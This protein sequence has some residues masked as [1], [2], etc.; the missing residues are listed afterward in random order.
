MAGECR[1]ARRIRIILDNASVHSS[2][3]A[4]QAI[5]QL[6]WSA[7][8]TTSLTQGGR[9][10]PLSAAVLPRGNLIERVWLNLHA[11]VTLTHRCRTIALFMDRVHGYLSGRNSQNSANPSLFRGDLRRTA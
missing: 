4:L 8:A 10:A 5:A 11:N 3:K 7:E 9:R 6:G 2:K 1:Q